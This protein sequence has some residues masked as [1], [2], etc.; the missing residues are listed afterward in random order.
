MRV[1]QG[2]AALAEAVTTHARAGR[3]VLG[4]G[5]GLGSGLELVLGAA[6]RVVVSGLELGLEACTADDRSERPC[7]D[8]GLLVALV[9]P[10]TQRRVPG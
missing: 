7:R 9:H 4:L 3:L 6:L 8:A 10:L 2:G 1:E 5:L